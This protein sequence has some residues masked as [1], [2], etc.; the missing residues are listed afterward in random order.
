MKTR[1]PLIVS[2]GIIL[3]DGQILVAQRRPNDKHPLKWEFPGGK[4]EIG[5][6]PQR[7]LI[8]ELREELEIDATISSE[9]ARHEHEYSDGNRV[10]L[11]FFVVPRFTGEPRARVFNQIRWTDVRDLPALDFLEGDLEFVK[12]LACGDFC[13]ELSMEAIS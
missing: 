1:T 4:I 10:H 6:S 7:A 11:L 13:N 9:L 8:R 2:A 3:R 5:E 12:R